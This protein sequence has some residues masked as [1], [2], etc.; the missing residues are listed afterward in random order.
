MLEFRSARRRFC[1]R[2][3]SKLRSAARLGIRVGQPCSA[4][5]EGPGW[6]ASELD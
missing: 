3:R 1:R 6:A 4:G 2:T 5:S